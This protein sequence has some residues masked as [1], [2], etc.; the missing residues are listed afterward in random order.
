MWCYIIYLQ[1]DPKS[2]TR[3]PSLAQSV[4]SRDS[5]KKGVSLWESEKRTR[6]LECPAPGCW[7]VVWALGVWSLVGVLLMPWLSVQAI[8][9]LSVR[10]TNDGG[11]SPTSAKAQQWEAPPPAPSLASCVSLAC[12]R[13][14]AGCYDWCKTRNIEQL[15]IE[16]ARTLLVSST[17][18]AW[19]VGLYSALSAC[20]QQLE[21]DTL[22]RETGV[23]SLSLSLSLDDDET[24]ERNS[25]LKKKTSLRRR[26]SAPTSPLRARVSS[27]RARTPPR[28][29]ARCAALAPATRV[30]FRSRL[31][32]Y[33]TFRVSDLDDQWRVEIALDS[34]AYVRASLSRVFFASTT[35]LRPRA[36]KTDLQ[37]ASWSSRWRRLR[38]PSS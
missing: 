11:G 22:V 15:T 5:K 16:R 4:R 20:V 18:T 7:H 13:A 27:A 35:R 19:S 8:R 33:G 30:F 29:A 36:L 9:T 1:I 26:G 23:P 25:G 38:S 32:I 14:G 31:R 37:Q 34:C 10:G 28:S 6:R 3:T 24:R 17:G 21:F 12:R 2:D